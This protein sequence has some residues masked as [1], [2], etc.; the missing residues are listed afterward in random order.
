MV[1]LR[2]NVVIMCQS[3]FKVPFYMLV[4]GI[5]L[6]LTHMLIYSPEDKNV[7]FSGKSSSVISIL[8]YVNH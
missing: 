3:C 7:P 2:Q 6:F 4:E 8:L 1:I 5:N